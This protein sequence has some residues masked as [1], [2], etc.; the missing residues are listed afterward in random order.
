M[1]GSH[2]FV[3]PKTPVYEP[4]KWYDPHKDVDLANPRFRTVQ[5]V[6]MLEAF[7]KNLHPPHRKELERRTVL[8]F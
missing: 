2:D 8:P 5:L 4:I 7:L 6:A 3:Y 1:S